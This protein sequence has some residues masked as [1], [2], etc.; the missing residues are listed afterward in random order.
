MHQHLYR[1][2][3]RILFSLQAGTVS[4]PL[5]GCQSQGKARCINKLVVA[6][7]VGPSVLISLAKASTS[8][9]PGRFEIVSTGMSC[10]VPLQSCD[11]LKLERL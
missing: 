11:F 5:H 7:L 4:Q 10:V 8:Q 9:R 2:N 3:N 1:H 6:V